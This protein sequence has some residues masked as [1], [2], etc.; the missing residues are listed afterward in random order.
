M[1]KDD[2]TAV[3]DKNS[4]NIHE[5]FKHIMSLGVDEEQMFNTY[6]MGIGYVLCVKPEDR[7]KVI[8]SIEDM[9]ERAYKIGYV[10][11]G[12]RGVCIK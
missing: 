7:Y 12:S 2:F 8:R 10:E 9:G 3:I 11:D 1:F 6:N 4:F 5:I